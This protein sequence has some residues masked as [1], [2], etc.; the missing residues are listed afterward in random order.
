MYGNPGA[1]GQQGLTLIE[2]MISLTLGLLIVIAATSA[3]LS[4]KNIYT[5]SDDATHIDDTGRFALE[6][7]A[8][9]VRQAAYVNWDRNESP[10]VVKPGMSPS[11]AGLDARSL[12]AN[13][14]GMTSPQTQSV[15]GSDLLSIQFF[16]AAD[17]TMLNC[18]GFPIADGQRGASIFYVAAD[19]AGEPQLYCKYSGDDGWSSD[20]VVRGVEAFHVL[21]G[22]DTDND[23]IPNRLLNAAAI[24]ALDDAAVGAGDSAVRNANTH[25]KK[26]VAVN[27]ALLVRGGTNADSG[28]NAASKVYDLFGQEYSEQHGAED[29]GVRLRSEDLPVTT[30]NR[31]RKVF[32]TTIQLRNAGDG[33]D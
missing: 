30:R 31:L 10:A 22:L 4:S 19:G 24:N 32:S 11:I 26:V 15:N 16:G 23:G 29:Q 25:W 13:T 28:G 5:A 8:R 21:Y 3:F 20:A 2:L 9:S 1:A 7:I 17:G 14:A 12:K 33:V 6:I 18:A 27:V